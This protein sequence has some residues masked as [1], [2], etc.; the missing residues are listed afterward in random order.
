LNPQDSKTICIFTAPQ[1]YKKLIVPFIRVYRLYYRRICKK[2]AQ[3]GC[4]MALS[5]FSQR[6]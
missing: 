1:E 2:S 5:L 3:D 4:R 6:L